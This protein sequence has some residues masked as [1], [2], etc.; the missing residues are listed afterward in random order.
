M[1]EIEFFWLR[2]EPFSDCFEQCDKCNELCGSTKVG[3]LLTT[4]VSAIFTRTNIIVGV[5]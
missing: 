3:N 4:Y 1:V 5:V 2:T